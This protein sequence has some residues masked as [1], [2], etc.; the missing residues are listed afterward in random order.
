[1]LR[2]QEESRR[3][4]ACLRSRHS[5]PSLL[6]ETS[7]RGETQADNYDVRTMKRRKPRQFEHA[8]QS[9]VITQ[10]RYMERQYPELRCLIAIPNGGARH[11]A[12]ARKLKAEGVRAGASDLFLA[13][14]VPHGPAGLWIEMKAPKGVVSPAQKDFMDLMQWAGFRAIVC[15]SA[16]EA[17]TEIKNY[18]KWYRAEKTQKEID[19]NLVF[20]KRQAD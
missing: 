4:L 19:D 9:S 1:M 18:L 8:I 7:G 11:I 16:E 17:I 13:L 20:L 6:P 5:A 10:C 12:V 15:Y 2:V 14:P 3:L